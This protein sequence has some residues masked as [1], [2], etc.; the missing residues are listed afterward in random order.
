MLRNL[1]T[2][3]LT[4]LAVAAIGAVSASAAQAGDFTVGTP[5][6]GSAL[7]T[8]ETDV[9]NEFTINNGIVRCT[10]ITIPA[11]TVSNGT[12][13][14]EVAPKYTGC[15]AFGVNAEIDMNGCTYLFHTTAA[16]GGA[17]TVDIKCPTVGGVK[18]QIVVTPTGLACKPTIGEQAGLTGLIFTNAVNATTGKDDLTLDVNIN[19]L[20][21]EGKGIKYTEPAGCAKPGTWTNGRYIGSVTINGFEDLAGPVEGNPVHITV[22]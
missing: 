9:I 8:A 7:I 22:D 12:T 16:A 15:K 13:T 20:K 2:L 19:P 21:E 18:Q 10:T 14:V 17:A 1:K 6:S 5:G 11:T 4:V 3:G